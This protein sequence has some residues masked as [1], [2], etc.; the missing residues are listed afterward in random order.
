VQQLSELTEDILAR[1]ADRV[2]PLI[3]R[4]RRVD[5]GDEKHRVKRSAHDHLVD[6]SRHHVAGRLNPVRDAPVRGRSR[7]LSTAGR[8]CASAIIAVT[9][10]VSGIGNAFSPNPSLLEYVAPMDT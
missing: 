6:P 2:A 5:H 4:R 8:V 7:R 9:L 10:E 3:R 1:C